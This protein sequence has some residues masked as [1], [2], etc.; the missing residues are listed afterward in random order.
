MAEFGSVRN[1]PTYP[2]AHVPGNVKSEKFE[3]FDESCIPTQPPTQ[4]LLGPFQVR[5]QPLA[6]NKRSQDIC[7]PFSDPVH[8]RVTNQLLDTERRFTAYPFR[9]CCLV[10]HATENDLGILQ[11]FDSGLGTNYFRDC[12]L[13]PDVV[14]VLVGHS[15]HS[16][17]KGL[18]R[19]EICR[20]VAQ[21]HTLS[22]TLAEG[23]LECQPL[24]GPVE[25]RLPRLF[26][27]AQANG[28]NADRP[29][30]IENGQGVLETS[31]NFTDEVC[32]RDADIGEGHVGILNT[33]ASFELT[34]LPYPNSGGFHIEDEGGMNLVVCALAF[35]S[36]DP[37]GSP[38]VPL[39]FR[40][41]SCDQ[42]DIAGDGAVR[43]P[44]LLAIYE[45]CRAAGIQ[46]RFSL[47][48]GSIRAGDRFGERECRDGFPRHEG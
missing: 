12:G 43:T 42:R 15:P 47:D 45:K 5:T 34:S 27:H 25:R 9:I 24:V 6:C 2:Q 19:K 40:R 29:T 46:H 17:S 16:E 44:Q 20:H 1:C 22:L 31:T 30:D 14:K 36:R 11:K 13:D 37:Q 18:H 33:P 35:W 26:G 8:L 38:A 41:N 7:R 21:P 23:L 10:P 28:W 39:P 3:Q 4:I 48:I 32:R